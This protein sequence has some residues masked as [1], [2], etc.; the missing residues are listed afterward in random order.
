[1][2]YDNDGPKTLSSKPYSPIYKKLPNININA[3]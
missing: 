3:C 2:K 1:M